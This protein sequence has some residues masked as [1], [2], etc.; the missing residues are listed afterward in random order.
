MSY[1]K[2]KCIDIDKITKNSI[3]L[4]IFKFANLMFAQKTFSLTFIIKINISS[5]SIIYK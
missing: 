3:N 2:T 1:F 4:T 5:L